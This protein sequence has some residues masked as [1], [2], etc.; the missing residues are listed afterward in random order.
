MKIDLQ[1]SHIGVRIFPIKIDV[2]TRQAKL[3]N[4]LGHWY[5]GTRPNSH[6]KYT[7]QAIKLFENFQFLWVF[8]FFN[9]LKNRIW[10]VRSTKQVQNKLEKKHHLTKQV[11]PI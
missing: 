11:R 7:T 8:E 6:V 3:V 10:K 2:H 9:I 1:Q 4:A 5:E